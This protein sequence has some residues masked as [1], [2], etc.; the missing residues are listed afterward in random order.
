M[1]AWF[2]VV[3]FYSKIQIKIYLYSWILLK[4]MK[5]KKMWVKLVIPEYL[6]R[7][8]GDAFRLLDTQQSF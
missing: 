6:L 2:S 5:Q 4:K 7:Y 1:N 3:V 8:V